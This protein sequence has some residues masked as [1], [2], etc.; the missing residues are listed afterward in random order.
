[1]LVEKRMRKNP[2]TITPEDYLASALAN[3]HKG[4]FRR[5][6]VKDWKLVGIITGRD[7]RAIEVSNELCPSRQA[8]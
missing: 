4:G 3:I 1:M 7:R 5:S 2:Q 8:C 6:V